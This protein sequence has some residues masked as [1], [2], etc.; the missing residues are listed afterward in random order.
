MAV[1]NKLPV[2]NVSVLGILSLLTFSKGETSYAQAQ[3][4]NNSVQN[5]P[6]VGLWTTKKEDGVF[7]I[8]P[9]GQALC[10]RFVGMQ[11]QGPIAPLNKK[12]HSQCNFLMLRNFTKD[13][14]GKRWNGKIADPRDEKLYDAKIWLSKPNELKLRGYMG[15][16]LFGETHTWHRFSG[17]I[18]NNCKLL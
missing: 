15:I 17:H 3:Q 8:Y 16:S 2:F 13:E 18:G 6:E 7:H 14:D 4:A 1:L 10:G 5:A 9:C 11:Y 12:N